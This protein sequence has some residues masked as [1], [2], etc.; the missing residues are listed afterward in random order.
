MTGDQERLLIAVAITLRE[1]FAVQ[2][3]L[4]T[5][6]QLN[7]ALKPWDLDVGLFTVHAGSLPSIP[8]KD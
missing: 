6:R 7:D 2:M 4:D 3:D 1:V 8:R 5:M